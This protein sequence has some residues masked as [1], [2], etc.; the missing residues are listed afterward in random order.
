MLCMYFKESKKM[1]NFLCWFCSVFQWSSTLSSGKANREIEVNLIEQLS[2]FLVEKG[3]F[4]FSFPQHQSLLL[5]KMTSN[6]NCFL[7]P[8]NFYY[9]VGVLIPL[10][11]T[12]CCLRVISVLVSGDRS[13][14]Q[15]S[16]F[17]VSPLFFSNCTVVMLGTSLVAYGRSLFNLCKAVLVCATECLQTP[18]YELWL[19]MESKTVQTW[20]LLSHAEARDS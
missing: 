8:G 17:H 19:S 7:L 1:N 14:A 3:F 5:T 12:P 15:N 13:V 4:F 18:A 10:L 16:E 11:C 2:D 6:P 20:M 9:V